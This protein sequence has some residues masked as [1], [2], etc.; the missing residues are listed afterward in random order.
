MNLAKC[1]AET[2]GRIQHHVK[3]FSSFVH[4]FTKGNSL[5]DKMFLRDRSTEGVIFWQ[6][7]LGRFTDQLPLM[8]LKKLT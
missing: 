4:K 8:T 1:I 7:T 2:E 6:T 5:P 3:S